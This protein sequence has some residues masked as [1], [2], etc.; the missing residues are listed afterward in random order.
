MERKRPGTESE[1]KCTDSSGNF[2]FEEEEGEEKNQS[3]RR[4]SKKGNGSLESISS[5]RFVSLIFLYK[6]F[7]SSCQMA[8][9][10]GHWLVMCFSFRLLSINKWYF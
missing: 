10:F 3:K 2:E 1:E 9:S 4:K 7:P 5:F 6:H 8:Q